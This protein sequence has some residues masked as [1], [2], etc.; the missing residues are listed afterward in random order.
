MGRLDTKGAALTVDV[1]IEKLVRL[2]WALHFP[3]RAWGDVSDPGQDP[4]HQALDHR[5]LR[6]QLGV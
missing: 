5:Y 3:I 1:D 6:Q 4:L 2:Q